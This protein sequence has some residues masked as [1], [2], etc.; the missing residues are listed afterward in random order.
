[1]ILGDG[2]RNKKFR[3]KGG[4]SFTV[5]WQCCFGDLSANKMEK[6]PGQFVGSHAQ[7]SRR[8]LN[9]I[10]FREMRLLCDLCINRARSSKLPFSEIG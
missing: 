9:S 3:T 4:Y 5:D 2:D 1:M 10:E 7:V 6:N 8:V